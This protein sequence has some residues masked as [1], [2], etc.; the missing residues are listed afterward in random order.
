M[1]RFAYALLAAVALTSAAAS[2]DQSPTNKTATLSA[3]ESAFVA[4]IQKDL[5]ARYPT[6]ADAERA[7]YVRYTSEDSTGAISYANNQWVSDPTHPSQ[8]W[9]DKNGAL[10]GA[11]FSVLVSDHPSRPSLWGVDSG[12]WYEFDGHVHWVG[13]DPSTGKLTYDNYV[14]DHDWVPAGGSISNPSAATLVAMKK[15]PDAKDVVTIFHFPT[16]WDLIVWVKPNPNGAF[17]V[18]NPNVKP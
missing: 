9:Y 1:K 18:K 15:V 11:D 2:A 10:I 16:V 3:S 17:A 5:M 6:T 4:S 8:L 13:R 12:R 14:M 7:G